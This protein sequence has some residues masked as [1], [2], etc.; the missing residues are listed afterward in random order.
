[1]GSAVVGIVLLVLAG[2]LVGGVWSLYR[3]EASRQA[4]AVCGLLALLATVAGVM[5]L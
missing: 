1:M 4:V 2:V 3:Q 5:W